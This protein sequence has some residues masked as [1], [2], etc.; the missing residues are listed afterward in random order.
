MS[1]WSAGPLIRDLFG[2]RVLSGSG[3]VVSRAGALT[4]VY[5]RC[6]SVFAHRSRRDFQTR[7]SCC[8]ASSVAADVE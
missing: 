8:E 4:L 2:C 3:G 6:V 5:Q 1:E 7:C